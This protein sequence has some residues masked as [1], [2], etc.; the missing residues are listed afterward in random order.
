MICKYCNELFD[1]IKPWQVFCCQR[2]QQ[3]WHLQ[4]RKLR[5]REQRAAADASL[6]EKVREALAN[7]EIDIPANATRAKHKCKGCGRSTTNE[8]FCSAR[9]RMKFF[10][11]YQDVEADNGRKFVRRI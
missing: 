9:C 1:E 8:R 11:R 4:Q 2:C 3:D 5:N 10:S 7:I 6:A